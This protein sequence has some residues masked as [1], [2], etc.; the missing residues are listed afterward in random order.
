MPKTVPG[1]IP[2]RERRSLADEWREFETR[3][4][5]P[6]NAGAV[7]R[8]ETRRGF[9]AGAQM[10]FSLMTGGLDADHEPTDLDVAYIESL[11]QELRAYARDLTEGRA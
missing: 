6:M 2:L 3:I 11:S 10:M 1:A 4:L 8:Q 9:Y 5:N 7:Q